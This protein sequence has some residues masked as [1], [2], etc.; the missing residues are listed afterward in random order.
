MERIEGQLKD[1]VEVAKQVLSWIICAR[2]PL[3][4]FELEHALAVELGESQLDIDNLCRVEY[5][6]SVCAGLVVVDDESKVIRLVHYDTAILRSNTRKIVSG[7]RDLPNE[8]LC[9]VPLI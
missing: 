2:R 1:E 9:D 6:V 3:T 4:T 7:C 5:M 8:D